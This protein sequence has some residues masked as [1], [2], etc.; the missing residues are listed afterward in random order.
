MTNEPIADPLLAAVA[1]LR[2]LPV[3]ES[4]DRRV[5]HRC[6]ALLA[7]RRARREPRPGR[8]IDVMVAAA[9]AS[10]LA[11]VATEAVRLWQ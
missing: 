7:D 1:G 2:P 6:H 9:A 10:Y 5:R 4:H 3:R 8:L 11:A